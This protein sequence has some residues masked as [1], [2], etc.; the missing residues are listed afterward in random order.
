LLGLDVA[1]IASRFGYSKSNWMRI[2]ANLLPLPPETCSRIEE[3]VRVGLAEKC[4]L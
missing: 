2:E 3:F 4:G 1:W